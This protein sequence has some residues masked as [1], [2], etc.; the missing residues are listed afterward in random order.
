MRKNTNIFRKR[1][2]YGRNKE[3][4]PN[5]DI[6]EKMKAAATAK[7]VDPILIQMQ[8]DCGIAPQ[9]AMEN[10]RLC[11]ELVASRQLV[12]SLVSE[13]ARKVLAQFL[14]YVEDMDRSKRDMI[15]RYLHFGFTIYR[16]KDLV[17][18]LE[19]GET[20]DQ[21]F[22]QYGLELYPTAPTAEEVLMV[23]E[24]Y[25]LS[26]ETAQ[27][28][29]KKMAVSK[30]YLTFAA[31]LG[32]DSR[33]F[34]CIAAM[35]LYLENRDTM[36]LEQ[37]VNQAGDDVAVLAAGDALSQAPA[38][39][40]KVKKLL[41]VAGIVTIIVGAGLILYGAGS[42]I[43]ANKMV[44]GVAVEMPKVFAEFAMGTTA[45]GKPALIL[46]GV[47]QAVVDAAM[48]AGKTKLVAGTV[49]ALGGAAVTA[50]S[51]M[52]GELAGKIAVGKQPCYFGSGH[53]PRRAAHSIPTSAG[54]EIFGE[55]P[56]FWEFDEED[57]E[58]ETYEEDE[59][60]DF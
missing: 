2:S 46:G 60:I 42:L 33:N 36:T 8:T 12:H 19:Q 27:I 38:V 51:G 56:E 44:V 59:E 52:A 17:A 4:N 31:R 39:S 35:K 49:T 57:E 40:E 9:L 5:V 18:R 21:L 26:E 1:I 13:D 50:V 14:E 55:Y 3:K 58:D 34:E 16:K 43:A 48:A 20:L 10:A 37:A 29:W 15:L 28:L 32:E 30:D 6:Y 24:Q 11:M 23:M 47:S 41:L 53:S 45:A 54:E 7:K 22:Q 25:R